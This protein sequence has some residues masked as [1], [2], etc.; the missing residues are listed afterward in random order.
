M[1]IFDFLSIENSKCAFNLV[2]LQSL[3][4]KIDDP[5]VRCHVLDLI[6]DSEYLASS[7]GMAELASEIIY[8][9][10]IRPNFVLFYRDLLIS[11]CE[12]SSS[13][14]N[15]IVLETLFI[16]NDSSLLYWLYKSEIF[17]SLDTKIINLLGEVN[18]F[19]MEMVM[20]QMRVDSIKEGLKKHKEYNKFKDI[21]TSDNFEAL[22]CLV[23]TGYSPNSI[24]YLISIDDAIRLNEFIYE[25][26][27]KLQEIPVDMNKLDYVRVKISEMDRIKQEFEEAEIEAKQLALEYDIEYIPNEQ[28]MIFIEQYNEFVE[29]HTREIYILQNNDHKSCNSLDEKIVHSYVRNYKPELP[30]LK[31]MLVPMDNIPDM[32]CLAAM[33]GSCKCFKYLIDYFEE[34]SPG[35]VHFVLSSYNNEIVNICIEKYALDLKEG[36]ITAIKYRV[37]EIVDR[38]SEEL[39]TDKVNILDVLY[40]KN[41][42]VCLAML[43]DIRNNFDD[44]Q[45]NIILRA[46]L[47]KNTDF[48]IYLFQEKN[49]NIN[50]NKF[51]S[52]VMNHRADKLFEYIL[53]ETSFDCNYPDC[54]GIFHI[55]RAVHMNNYY[56]VENLIRYGANVNV[57]DSDNAT[58]LIILSKQVNY[59]LNIGLLLLSNN[60]NP[61]SKDV[62]GN[63]ALFY[64]AMYNNFD[65]G[66]MLLEHNADIYA[67]NNAGQNIRDFVGLHIDDNFRNLLDKYNI[68]FSDTTQTAEQTV[69][70]SKKAED[71]HVEPTKRKV[72]LT[73][74]DFIT[75]TNEYSKKQ[76]P[77]F[78]SYSDKNKSNPN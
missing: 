53:S 3:L 78:F 62:Y 6:N 7:F 52:D 76:L 20:L 60:A 56:Y 77:D 66:L 26:I 30:L 5:G 58:P 8:A 69:K 15:E 68:H 61:S 17:E 71:K 63:S 31:S 40:H 35:L 38:F 57:I 50:T 65:L 21:V 39:I 36:I 47:N 34:P 41:I 10:K 14:F 32:L 42:L 22:E 74:Y 59:D 72:V 44:V 25:S 70:V 54:N 73:D 1:S 23:N 2:N 64:C 11:L 18:S 19:Q 55:H 49:F 67:V 29:K 27:T 75:Y 45:H 51:L 13:Y 12:S 43:N 37:N 46:F 16:Y 4:I 33:F 24:E 9:A 48:V 28:Y